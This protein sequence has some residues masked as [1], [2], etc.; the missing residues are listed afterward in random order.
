MEQIALGDTGRTTTRL[1]FGCSSLMGAMGRRASLAIL[2]SAYDAGIRHFDVAPM[3]GYGEAEGCLGEFL[4]RHRPQVTVTT[5][6]GIPPAKN[7]SLISVARRVVGPLTKTLPSLKHRLALAA[8]AATRTNEKTTFTPQQAKTSLEH[9]L[10]ALRTDHI[11]LWLLH[12]ISAADLHDDALLSLL[13][14][15]VQRGTIGTFGIG[16]SVDKIPS[17]LTEHPAYC[18]TLQYEWSVLDPEIETAPTSPF[19][20]HHRA[21][22]ENFRSLHR[23]LSEDKQLCHRW[24]ASTNADL[25]NPQ[26]LAHL[27]LKAALVMNPKSVILFSSKNPRHIQLNVKTAEDRSL[28]APAREF[29]RLVQTE[30]NQL[31]LAQAGAS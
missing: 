21:L 31:S 1:G 20:I 11:D 27:M 28:E 2:E 3:Y 9:S 13:E 22:T 29:H 17:L 15:E 12:E 6:Y 30:R 7:S 23:A 19:R 14:Q 5:K 16:S 4:Q 10:V 24:S 25:N 8:N 26:D 18:R